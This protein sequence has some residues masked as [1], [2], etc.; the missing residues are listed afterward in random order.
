MYH[1]MGIREM[2]DRSLN[3]EEHDV[4]TKF[5]AMAL[6]RAYCA[7][8]LDVV[9]LNGD[10]QMAYA[11]S[12][13]WVYLFDEAPEVAEEK[14]NKYGVSYITPGGDEDTLWAVDL[15]SS[16]HLF[17]LISQLYEKEQLG[18]ECEC[19]PTYNTPKF[20]RKKLMKGYL[21]YHGLPVGTAYSFAAADLVDWFNE[22]FA[23]YVWFDGHQAVVVG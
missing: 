21:Q 7:Q 1:V 15:A 16:R 4:E 5:E 2:E 11:S 8:G 9:I 18:R 23:D 22:I 6:A 13:Y 14:I 19:V 20:V 10:G 3:R 12:V 17:D